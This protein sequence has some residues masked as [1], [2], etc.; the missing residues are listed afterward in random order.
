MHNKNR[1][2]LIWY[3]ELPQHCNNDVGLERT[4]AKMGNYKR[5]LNSRHSLWLLNLK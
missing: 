4:I 1:K 5:A 3:G 2:F